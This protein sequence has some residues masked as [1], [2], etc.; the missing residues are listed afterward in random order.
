MLIFYSG[1][2]QNNAVPSGSESVKLFFF[3]GSNCKVES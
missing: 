2:R 1:I 3:K